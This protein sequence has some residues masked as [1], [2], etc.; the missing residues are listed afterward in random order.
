[1]K[2]TNDFQIAKVQSQGVAYLLLNFFASFSLVLLN[3]ISVAYKKKRVVAVAKHYN[4]CK[5]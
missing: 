5:K 2:K 3:Y 4:A 1:M